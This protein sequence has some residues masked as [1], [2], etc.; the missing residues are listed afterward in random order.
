MSKR[1][2]RKQREKCK[3][4]GAVSAAKDEWA[5]LFRYAKSQVH[6]DKDI[7]LQYNVVCGIML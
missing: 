6:I 3:N 4:H 1:K 7:S 5:V 2:G